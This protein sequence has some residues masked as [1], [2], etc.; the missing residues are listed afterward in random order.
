MLKLETNVYLMNMKWMPLRMRNEI[1]ADDISY[2][3]M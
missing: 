1:L 2:K 3:I